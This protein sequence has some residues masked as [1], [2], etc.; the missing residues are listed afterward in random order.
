MTNQAWPE[1]PY[2][3]MEEHLR[4]PAP[5]DAD[6]RQGPDGPNAL[7]QSFL[8]RDALCDRARPDHLSIPYGDR[9]FELEFDFLDHVLRVTDDGQ[10]GNRLFRRTVADF[11]AEL[12]RALEE[13]GIEVRI[14]DM[15][16][17]MP[18]PICFHEDRSMRPTIPSPRTASGACWCDRA[19]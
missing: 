8:A 6:R 7:A 4:H 15:P 17:E 19:R 9:R 1:L 16:N 10:G 11:Y 12:M 18:E 3:G 5:L 13:L 2:D 14:N